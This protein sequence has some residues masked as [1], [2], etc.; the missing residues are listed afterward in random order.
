MTCFAAN[1]AMRP[2]SSGM[3]SDSPMTLP[4]SSFSGT[5]TATWPVLRSRCTRASLGSPPACVSFFW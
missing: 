5:S 2:K 1:A 3:V 4:S